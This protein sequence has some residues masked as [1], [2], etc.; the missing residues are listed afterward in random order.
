M[1]KRFEDE[2]LERI[3]FPENF[4]FGI[5]MSGFQFEM[6][7]S[8]EAIDENSDWWIWV[9]DPFNI[10]LGIVSGDLPEHGAGY[11]N[12]YKKDHEL[13]LSLNIDSVRVGIEWSRIFPKPTFDVEVEVKKEN[14][15]ITEVVISKSTIEEL[16]NNANEEALN[17][18][19][20]IL[21][22]LKS[23]ELRVMVCLNHFTLPKW[24]H[25]PIE[26]RLFGLNS[27]RNGWLS[28]RS[29]IEFVKYVGFIA[30]N[31]KDLVDEWAIF[32]EPRAVMHE[33]FLK[34]NSGFPPK[35]ISYKS[36]ITGMVN[37]VEAHARAYDVLKSIDPLKPVGI[38]YDILL[39]EPLN[40]NDIIASENAMYFYNWWFLDAIIRGEYSRGFSD[41]WIIYR[42]DLVGKADW[43]GVN[44]YSRLVVEESRPWFNGETL[45]NWKVV[46]GYGFE[47]TPKL[48]T[49][50]GN[51]TS[52][53]GWE[54]YPQ[55]LRKVLNKV[56]ARY[57][58]PI[59]V[60][61]NGVADSEDKLRPYVITSHLN[62]IHKAIIE[63]NVN[64]LGYYHWSLM[65][66]YEWAH[67]YSMKYGL[68]EVN[69]QT[70]ERRPRHSAKLYS[71]IASDRK[72]PIL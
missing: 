63:D 49:K 55:G 19:R 70:K 10:G 66:N 32:N 27:P 64:V 22:D 35:I 20:T 26:L 52:D 59:I 40:E 72:V 31:L 38:I 67:G 56:Y 13:M 41:K 1:L 62:E 68:Y 43:I 6:G 37:L 28:M 34:P 65:D 39:T 18:Y 25:N 45:L 5:S 54:I 47:S 69:F 36:Y 24:L 30:Y 58:L 17:H 29:I 4:R 8:I 51:P 50:A 7:C 2:V 60:T 11:W 42:K 53:M 48:K 44:Y 14:G 23:K 12:L 3:A 15:N 9:H 57:K 61:E 21:E 33:G 16:R 71:K 46:K